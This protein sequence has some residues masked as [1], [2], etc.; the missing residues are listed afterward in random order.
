MG[1]T[2]RLVD[3]SSVAALLID[4]MGGTL[5]E[6]KV[7][8]ELAGWVPVPALTDALGPLA[9]H[10]GAGEVRQTAFA[11]LDQHARLANVKS[12]LALFPSASDARRWS[13]LT[14]VLEAGDPYLLSTSGDPM[15][16]ARVL[17]D[18]PFVFTQHAQSVLHNRQLR[19]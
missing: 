11:A 15:C 4:R 12:L 9:E 18:V 3:P 1:H 8:A 17:A 19:Q 14:A 5:R 16:L 2:L 7:A 6:R 13:L 10:D